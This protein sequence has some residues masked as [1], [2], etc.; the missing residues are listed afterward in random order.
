MSAHQPRLQTIAQLIPPLTY[1]LHKGDCGRIAAIGGCEEY[2]GAPYFAASTTLRLGA[3]LAYVVCEKDAASV[4]KAYSPD[5]IVNPYLRSTTN[6]DRSLEEIDEKLKPL[7]SKM[8]AVSVGSGLGND[9]KIRESAKRAIQHARSLSIPVV[10]DADSL[11]IVAESPEIIHGYTNAILTPNAPE[12]DR[13]AKSLGVEPKKD[14]APEIAAQRVAS[15]LDGVTVVRKGKSDIIT[16]GVRLFICDEVGGLRRCGG[17]GDILSGAI[18][19]FLAWGERYKAGAWKHTAEIHENEFP[20]LAAFAAC[21]ITRHASFLA[22]E[23]YGRATQSS[24]VLEQVDIA[25]DNKFEE[26]LKTVKS[27]KL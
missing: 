14:E 4:I 5:L 11:A 22:Y 13:L 9:L 26:I 23:E 17:Q 15:A 12:F 2:T 1:N 10:L 7:L 25:F 16:D 8:H 6:T 27:P 19:T 3:D 24:S 21:T 18:A 20:M